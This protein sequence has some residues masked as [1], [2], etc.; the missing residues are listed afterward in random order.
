MT[1]A[2]S[3]ITAAAFPQTGEDRRG[4]ASGADAVTDAVVAPDAAQLQATTE[5]LNRQA[6]QAQIGLQFRV[7]Q[8]TGRLVISVI[9]QQDGKVLLQIPG[10]EALSIAQS[11]ERLKAQ[12]P[13]HLLKPQEV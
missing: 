2:I 11:L 13:A 7:D 12:L 4:S 1:D 6:Q 10:E 3:M 5:A 9:D 8:L